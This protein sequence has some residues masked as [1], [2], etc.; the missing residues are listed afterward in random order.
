MLEHDLALGDVSVC[1]SV[2]PSVI[3]WCRLKTNHGRTIWFSLSVISGTLVYDVNFHT[4]RPK[5]QGHALR[6]H[7][8]GLRWVKTAILDQ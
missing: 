2:R 4:V 5:S 6:R 1:L 7:Q 3:R 8:T